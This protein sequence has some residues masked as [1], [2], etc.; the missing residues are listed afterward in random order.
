[1]P[2]QLTVLGIESSC[3][4]TAVAILRAAGTDTAPEIL[5]SVISS[6][7]AI[8]R[9]HGGVVPELAS[10][11]HSADL[12]RVIREACLKAGLTPHDI[13]VFG[14]TGGPGLVAALLVGN[15]TAKALAIA[16][17]K[18]F[19]SVNHLEGHLLS[20]FVKRPGGPVPHLGMVVSGGHT[21]LVDVRAVGDYRLIGRS[22]DD[23]AGEA[24]DK[25]G[26]MLDLPYPGGPEIDRMA[27]GGNPNAFPFPRA[28]IKEQSANMSFSGLKTAVLYTLPKLT[29]GGNP[30][31]L[32]EQTMRDLCASFQR[33]VTDVLI[34]KAM[35]ALRA[36]GHRIL[37][38]SGGVSCN[39]EL[40]SRLQTACDK[41]GIELILPDFDLTTD[42]A[43][44]IAYVTWLKAHKKLFHSPEE[45]VDPNLK[46]TE[47]LNRSKFSTHGR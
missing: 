22:M 5:S 14:A 39:A 37:S 25:V 41:A 33:A 17:N 19:V 42:N 3:D 6:Q 4:E 27:R 47:E 44:M 40:R 31:D 24:F 16:T 9:L 45:D 26:K 12:P 28:L 20:P 23:A 11:N 46:L 7:I 29:P 15:S 34:H 1:M 32:P 8:H 43:A 2:E 13:D 18:P 36:S 10:R 21:L 35:Y 30:N 38:L